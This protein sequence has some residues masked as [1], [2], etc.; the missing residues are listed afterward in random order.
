MA[1]LCGPS[2]IE[3]EGSQRYKTQQHEVTVEK[4][5]NCHRLCT[6]SSSLSLTTVLRNPSEISFGVE[7]QYPYPKAWVQSIL[8]F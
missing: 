8:D 7:V 2:G 4:D 1:G 5:I 3:A 6:W